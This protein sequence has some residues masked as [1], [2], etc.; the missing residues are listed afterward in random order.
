M[1][2]L[3]ASPLERTPNVAPCVGRAP[4]AESNTAAVFDE[5]CDT[6]AAPVTTAGSLLTAVATCPAVAWGVGAATAGGA[7]RIIPRTATTTATLVRFTR[8]RPAAARWPARA[9]A[10]ARFRAEV[11][12]PAQVPAP[13]R[14]QA[15]AAARAGVLA[16][17]LETAGAA[18]TAEAPR[19]PRPT[20][21]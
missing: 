9:R 7:T 14:A 20:P 18:A 8:P 19:Q 13:A 12:A 10:A 3:A 1:F 21:P 15:L 17:A 11:P 4:S 5:A 6:Y 16:R 2:T